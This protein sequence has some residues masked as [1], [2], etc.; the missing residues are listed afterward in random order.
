MVKWHFFFEFF[1]LFE[2]FQ[3][4]QYFGAVFGSKFPKFQIF[5]FGI[6]SK[7]CNLVFF[8]S[9]VDA[10]LPLALR[11]IN[12]KRVLLRCSR[13]DMLRCLARDLLTAKND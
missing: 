3:N 7:L 11:K 4:F 8:R 2:P 13:R 10:E 6:G 5:S 9:E 1:R 12:F